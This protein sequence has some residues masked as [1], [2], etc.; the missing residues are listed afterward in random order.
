MDQMDWDEKL[1]LALS[2]IRTVPNCTTGE[3]P[4]FLVFGSEAR[5]IADVVYP[6]DYSKDDQ[7]KCQDAFTKTLDRLTAIHGKV[8]K[9]IMNKN[10]K[11]LKHQNK[12]T[13]KIIETP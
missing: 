12:N 9:R 7:T 13:H 2:S 1:S 3:S 5:T 6:M 11:C 4:H 8:R 10:A